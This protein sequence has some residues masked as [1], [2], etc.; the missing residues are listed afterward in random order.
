MTKTNNIISITKYKKK[1]KSLKARSEYC[2]Q[3]AEIFY[4]LSPVIDERSTYNEIFNSNIPTYI[5]EQLANDFNSELDV[6]IKLLLN[7]MYD[8]YISACEVYDAKKKEPK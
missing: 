4:E 2:S 5:L 7:S 6:G 8:K 3:M 1:K